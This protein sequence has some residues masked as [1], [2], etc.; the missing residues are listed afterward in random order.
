MLPKLRLFWSDLKYVFKDITNKLYGQ[1]VNIKRGLTRG[2]Y[3][4]NGAWTAFDTHTGQGVVW[5][6]TFLDW[7]SRHWR[8]RIR[9][10][11]N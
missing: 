11:N 7:L 4:Y 5:N 1:G 3:Y 6:D 8:K 10:D 2:G 9:K